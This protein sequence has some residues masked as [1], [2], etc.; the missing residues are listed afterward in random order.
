MSADAMFPEEKNASPRQGGAPFVYLDSAAT[1]RV[2]EASAQAAAGAMRFAWANP[3]STHHAGVEASRLV[4]ES[5]RATA[6]ELGAEPDRVFF[7]SGGTEANNTAVLGGARA[8]ARRGRRV[9]TSLAEHSSVLDS[10]KR[11]E[12]EGFDCVYLKPDIYGAVSARAVEEALTDDTVLVSLMLVNNETGAVNPVRDI[13]A[14][15]KR[16]CPNA[17]FHCDAVQ[18]FGKLRVRPREL[19]CDALSVS[20]HKLHA[21]KGVGALY[22]S[23]QSASRFLPLHYGGEQQQGFRPGTE[24]VPLIAA[25][26]E[27]VR[28]LPAAA[29]RLERER[30]LNDRLRGMLRSG[31]YRS[32]APESAI[33]SPEDGSPAIL[34]LATG[35]LRSETVLN[36]L[37]ARGIYISSGSACAKGRASHVIKA[38]G[39]PPHIADSALRVS[40]CRDS[41]ESEADAFYAALC[42]ALRTLARFRR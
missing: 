21:P 36:F 29:E 16:R 18:A 26:A 4:E 35:C 19:G 17:L 42:E 33:I 8:M 2:S 7:T 12:K 10:V 1:T 27:A 3:S 11:L 5:R 39:L 31:E 38:L 23:K 9:I 41:T 28:E 30:A 22:I 14:A 13:A 24:P 25:F 20:G 37:S 40:F 6:A 15:V 32:L 34:C